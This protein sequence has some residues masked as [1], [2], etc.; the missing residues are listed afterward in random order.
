MP[1]SLEICLPPA[2]SVYLLGLHFNPEGEAIRSFKI[3]ATFYQTTWHYIPK[4]VCSKKYRYHFTFQKFS[5]TIWTLILSLADISHKKYIA[6]Q[7]VSSVFLDL[8]S[9]QLSY[10][11]EISTY[12][13][14]KECMPFMLRLMN[15]M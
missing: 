13:Y 15:S 1:L 14:M 6:E 11:D 3:S 9:L 5:L 8:I 2:L 7:R 4:G 12:I 10:R